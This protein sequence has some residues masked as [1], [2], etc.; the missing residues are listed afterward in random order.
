MNTELSSGSKEKHYPIWLLI[1]FAFCSFHIFF[2]SSGLYSKKLLIA[3]KEQ[4][5]IRELPPVT[6]LVLSPWFA[7]GCSAMGILLL[8]LCVMKW[9]TSS[10]TAMSSATMFL[11]SCVIL[12]GLRAPIGAVPLEENLSQQE[13][14]LVPK[15]SE[16]EL[17]GYL[18]VRVSPLTRFEL[19]GIQPGDILTAIGG[20]LPDNAH[21]AHQILRKNISHS[22]V[23]RRGE[24]VK[25]ITVPPRSI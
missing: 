16:S 11:L 13:V 1:L 24:E 22:L 4:S 20:E 17:A 18:I 15:F 14:L 9:R 25:E 3:M 12:I 6:E 5:P 21:S 7:W 8:L 2:L 10:A 19:A 23:V